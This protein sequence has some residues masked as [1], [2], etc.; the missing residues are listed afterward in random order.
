MNCDSP[1]FAL[2][3]TLADAEFRVENRATG[4]PTNRI[5]PEQHKLITQ[6]GAAAQPAGAHRHTPP[7][8][9]I[10]QRLRPVRLTAVH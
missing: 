9:A 4:R 6:D 3:Q 10:V 8:I 5:M 7:A 1:C 2:D